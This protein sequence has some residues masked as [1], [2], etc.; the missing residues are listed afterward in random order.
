VYSLIVEEGTRIE[1]DISSGKLQ[2]IDEEIERYIYWYIKRRLE[3]EGY[4]HY[5]ISNFAKPGFFCKHNL[6]CWKQKE[7][8]GFGIAS[9]SYNNDCRFKN[10]DDIN[11][12]VSNLNKNQYRANI[13]V[14]EKQ[15]K[16]SKMDEYMILNLRTLSGV[17]ISKF[18][19]L[20]NE[21]PYKIYY[22]KIE[23]LV[24]NNLIVIDYDNIKLS[25]KGLDLANIVWEEFI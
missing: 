16:Q 25:K 9:S 24:K 3:K 4:I 7:Y 14:E 11:K 19:E 10:I 21:S 23:K 2:L 5:E 15:N 18:K 6:D 17:K 1:K 12:Y 13:I 20:F 22:K 8:L